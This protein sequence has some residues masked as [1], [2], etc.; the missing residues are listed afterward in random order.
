MD[1]AQ[2]KQLKAT[3]P[4]FKLRNIG[5]D[6]YACAVTKYDGATGQPLPDPELFQ[7]TLKQLTD[8]RTAWQNNLDS[9]DEMIA[10]AKAAA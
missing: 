2:Y 4:G 3:V 1:I 9:L 6:V 8:L 5:S 7:C 10:D